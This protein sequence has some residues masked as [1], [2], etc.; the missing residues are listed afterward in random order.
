MA[1]EQSTPR[2]GSVWLA[3][4]KFLKTLHLFFKMASCHPLA[5]ELKKSRMRCRLEGTAGLVRSMLW[6]LQPLCW[7]EEVPACIPKPA[8]SSRGANQTATSKT[9][10]C[11]LSIIRGLQDLSSPGGETSADPSTAS[12]QQPQQ[13]PSVLV[14]P[15]K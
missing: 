3:L 11:E 13:I 9:L 2:S 6:T 4:N 15:Y 10:L 12:Q 14:T 1:D 8:I 7:Q 5:N